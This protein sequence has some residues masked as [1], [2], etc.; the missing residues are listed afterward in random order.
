MRHHPSLQLF[1]LGTL[2]LSGLPDRTSCREPTETA[3]LLREVVV[4]KWTTIAKVDLLRLWPGLQESPGVPEWPAALIGNADDPYCKESFTVQEAGGVRSLDIF[5]SGTH[6]EVAKAAGILSAAVRFP[7]SAADRKELE[8]KR[9]LTRQ[10]DRD[11][12]PLIGLDLELI[13]NLNGN[14]AGW[15]VRLTV[16][17]FD[18][19]R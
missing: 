6:E 19:A 10:M 5:F 12:V 16:I 3:R 18:A 2:L 1:L 15:G 14:P 11:L 13:K 4:P 7:L 17:T 8:R 9:F